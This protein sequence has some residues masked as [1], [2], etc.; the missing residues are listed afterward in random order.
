M[1]KKIYIYN[2]DVEKVCET[3]KACGCVV[4]K[5]CVATKRGDKLEIEGEQVT[6]SIFND[7]IDGESEGVSTFDL[8]ITCVAIS[9]TVSC[10][11]AAVLLELVGR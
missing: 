3:A 4:S 1:I 11:I 5:G 7:I 9:V 8:L 2:V 6:I 10:T